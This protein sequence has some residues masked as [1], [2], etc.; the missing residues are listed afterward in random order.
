MR[1]MI[2]GASGVVGRKVLERALKSDTF[3]RIVAPT[4]RPLPAAGPIENPVIDFSLPLPDGDWWNVDAV[5]CCLGT[6]RRQA[7]SKEAFFAIDHDLV[8]AC[9]EA[10][11]RRG[12]HTFALNSSL[13]ADPG[14]RNFYL[15]TKGQTETDLGVLGFRRLVL[16]RPSLIDAEREEQRFGEQLGLR[17]ARLL[18]PLVP[19]R[20]RAVPAEQIAATLLQQ[21]DGEAGT[22]VIESDQIG[23]H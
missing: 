21:L 16:V 2:L 10:A 7:G 20:Y 23:R 3:S 5:I 12:A 4:R 19:A 13:G 1:L 8:L 15:Q 18:A 9:A 17:A 6:T 11:H 14:S 22:T